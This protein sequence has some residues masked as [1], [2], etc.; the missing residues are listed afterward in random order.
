MKILISIF[1][2]IVIIST[3]MLTVV[4]PSVN[5]QDTTSA[6]EEA[7]L[8]ARAIKPKLQISIPGLGN[9]SDS[10]VIG[11]GTGTDGNQCPVGSVCVKTINVYL[12][13]VYK[14]ASGAAIIFAIV[15][16]MIGGIQYMVGSS[17]G[18]TGAGKE[19]MINAAIGLILVFSTYTI[20]TFVNPEITS[21]RPLQLTVIKY[22]KDLDPSIITGGKPVKINQ[23]GGSLRDPFT[24]LDQNENEIDCVHRG[25]PLKRFLLG[26]NIILHEDIVTKIQQVAYS[27]SQSD[28]NKYR[29]VV[30]DSSYDDI[31][32]GAIIFYKKC[33]LKGECDSVCDPF[34]HEPELSP[35]VEDDTGKYELKTAYQEDKM[36]EEEVIQVISDN[37]NEVLSKPTATMICSHMTGF[38]VDMWCAHKGGTQD[39]SVLS[40]GACHAVLENEMRKA[41]FCRS[42]TSPWHFEYGPM[43][44][45]GDTDECDWIT[46]VV[47]SKGVDDNT[48]TISGT[49]MSGLEWAVEEALS[50]STLGL[51]DVD[52]TTIEI[53]TGKF[54]ATEGETC[55]VDYSRA[56]YPVNLETFGGILDASIDEIIGIS[57]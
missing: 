36:N 14:Y 54:A 51:A 39:E 9:F 45:T 34:D 38:A 48:C 10:L 19:R 15:L 22:V 25:I 20:L 52:L 24:C 55:I 17:A 7:A 26:D 13:A 23:L 27:V 12:N 31:E 43:A 32:Q 4:V 33:V 11:T 3:L 46:G 18:N 44:V 1:A 6:K 30:I 37:V 50:L 5:A 47:P 53:K 16:I 56:R 42:Y 29:A 2:T 21:L 8:N 28:T 49:V 35:W 57:L 40:S 41:G